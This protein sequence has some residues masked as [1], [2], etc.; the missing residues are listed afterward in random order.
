MQNPCGFLC[1][2]NLR[3]ELLMIDRKGVQLSAQRRDAVR[4]G[5]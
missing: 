4:I 2:L 3:Q 1:A 5:W